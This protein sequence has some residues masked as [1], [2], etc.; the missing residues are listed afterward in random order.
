[1]GKIGFV[2]SVFRPFVFGQA[3]NL[4]GI[5]LCQPKY[6]ERT[7]RTS[8][9]EDAEWIYLCIENASLKGRHV[10]HTPYGEHVTVTPVDKLQNTVIASYYHTL[11]LKWPCWFYSA[12]ALQFKKAFTIE[13]ICNM[14]VKPELK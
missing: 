7:T 5:P 13:A 2:L 8:P 3:K 6:G 14:M 9:E 12:A 1:M 11:T 10:E 4:Q